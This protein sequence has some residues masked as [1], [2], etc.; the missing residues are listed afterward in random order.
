M[1]E[2]V[3]ENLKALYTKKVELVRQMCFSCKSCALPKLNSLWLFRIIIDRQTE[4]FAQSCPT[5]QPHRLQPTRLLC[6]WDSPSKNTGVGC[7]SLL[8]GIFPTLGLN[9][10]LPYCRQI[11]YHLSHQGLFCD[12]SLFYRV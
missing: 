8:Q 2:S 6:P 12:K 3:K 10:S 9:L 5:L 4:R 1:N 11:L 7:H